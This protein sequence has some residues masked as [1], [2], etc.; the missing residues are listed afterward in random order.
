MPEK[1]I[2]MIGSASTSMGGVTTVVNIYR[3]AGLFRDWPI[4]YI[5]TH[6][7]GSKGRK[8]L[9]ATAAILRFIGL[10]G[11]GRVALLHAHT[12]ARASFWRKSMFMLAAF[13]AGCPVIIHLHDSGFVDFYWKECGPL[14]KRYVLFVLNRAARIV[15]LSNQWKEAISGITQ[16]PN[17]VA[18]FNPIAIVS[19]KGCH[20][21]QHERLP[22]LLF[23]GRLGVQKGIY[24][25]LEAV[26][27]IRA[28]FPDVRLLCGGDGD[29]DGV[30][31]RAKELEVA[32]NIS[33]LGWVAGEE[34]QRLLAEAAV[35]VL[36]SY[37]EG[38]PMGVLEAMAAGLPVV[39]TM[40][41]GI[42]D[43]MQDGVEGYLV[44]PG[45][46]AAL[47]NKIEA[48]LADA[49]LRE[50]MGL[51]GQQKVDAYFLPEKVF[52]RIGA[53]YREMGILPNSQGQEA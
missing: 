24:D 19:A 29:L 26:S 8:L 44:E 28:R 13:V 23:L 22:L 41:G 33:I 49:A 15:V 39:S 53:L 16:N 34:K 32:E 30:A 9:T 1:S 12:S 37:N 51:A 40:V 6:V 48:L 2:V 5:D 21:P 52:P 10:L 45:N 14:R 43:A 27:R 47:A 11:R 3:R 17:I 35:Y 25:L 18:I 50:Q 7:D 46:V 31:Q 36:P 4:V 20:T 42:P 38:L